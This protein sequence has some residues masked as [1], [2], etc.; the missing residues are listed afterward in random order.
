MEEGDSAEVT[1]ISKEAG[2]TQP[3]TSIKVEF[4][5]QISQV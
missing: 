5:R 2:M 3:L 1:K 4:Q